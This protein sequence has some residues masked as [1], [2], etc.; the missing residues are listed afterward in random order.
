[1]LIGIIAGTYS[2]MFIATPVM[3]WFYRNRRP[4]FKDEDSS[5]E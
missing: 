3:I 5:D 4:E 1:M 2:T